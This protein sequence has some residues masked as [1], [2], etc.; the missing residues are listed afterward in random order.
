[1]AFSSTTG[2][3]QV[4][5]ASNSNW[6]TIPMKYMALESYKITP[7]Q[8]LDLDSYRSET[9]VL[10]RNVLEHTATKV[11]FNTPIIS[12]TDLQAMLTIIKNGYTNA[13][14][15]RLKLKYYD[16][17]TDDYKTGTFYRPDIEYTMRHIDVNKNAISYESV[18]VAFIEY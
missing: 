5:N 7:D 10:L 18:R 1:M 14:S 9:G 4:Q 17:E 15:H 11:E 12:S 13:K 6:V 2:L 16:P 8:M 3:V